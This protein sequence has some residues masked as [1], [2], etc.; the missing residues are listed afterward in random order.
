MTEVSGKQL[1]TGLVIKFIE[2]LGIYPPGNIV[3]MSNGE[4]AIIV[5]T[6]FI[7]RLKPK[8]TVLLDK[9]KKKIKPHLVDLA[10]MGL[11]AEEGSYTIRRI[12]RA[13]K[14]GF[15]LNQLYK[16]KLVQDS[17]VAAT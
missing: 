3:E 12:V 1:D 7:Q 15:D 8:I 6:N 17:L 14:Y 11:D 4:V 16:M 10:K 9:D 13:D 2:S 5:E